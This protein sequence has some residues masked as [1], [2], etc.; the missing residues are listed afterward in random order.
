[1][2]GMYV[3]K[4]IE[5]TLYVFYWAPVH[6]EF[7]Y[8]NPPLDELNQKW[9]VAVVDTSWVI[10]DPRPKHLRAEPLGFE[11]HKPYDILSYPIIEGKPFKYDYPLKHYANFIR[12]IA[13]NGLYKDDGS[14][15]DIYWWA[16][17]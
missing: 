10:N 12:P 11:L 9:G 8:P 7:T 2:N 1:M 6:P 16:S 3:L 14:K 13:K 17:G 15:R 4:S 5:G